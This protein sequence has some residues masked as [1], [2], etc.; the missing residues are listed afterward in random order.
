VFVLC[1]VVLSGCHRLSYVDKYQN[2]SLGWGHRGY[3]ASHPGLHHAGNFNH[4]S[5]EA[6][7]CRWHRPMEHIPQV[8]LELED[9]GCQDFCGKHRTL[10]KKTLS[11]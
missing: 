5:D 7:Q 2:I 8:L 6:V 11:Y 3:I 9:T 4:Y 10:P 1:V